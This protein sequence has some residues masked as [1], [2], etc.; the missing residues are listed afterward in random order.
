MT[1]KNKEQMTALHLVLSNVLQP[2]MTIFLGIIAWG[3]VSYY[4][5]FEDWKKDVNSQL[6]EH[7]IRLILIESRL[8]IKS[9]SQEKNNG[10]WQVTKM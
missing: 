3:I 2:L 1:T 6:R 7:E 9:A 10:S 5:S 4:N 8:K